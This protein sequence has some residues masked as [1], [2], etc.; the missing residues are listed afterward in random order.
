MRITKYWLILV[1]SFLSACGGDLTSPDFFP[2]LKGVVVDSATPT[3]FDQIGQTRQYKLLA[4]YSTPPGSNPEFTTKEVS[5][6]A[7]QSTNPT[8]ASV[9]ANGTVT[10]LRNGAASIRGSWGGFTS[11]PFS[12]S[13]AAPVLKSIS[14]DPASASVPLGLSQ[15]ITAIGSY[16]KTDGSTETHTVTELLS[17]LSSAPTVASVPEQGSTVTVSTLQQNATPVQIKASAV[18]ADGSVVERSAAIT[19]IAPELQQVVVLRSDNAA[20][21][22]YAVPRGASINLVAKGIYTDSSTPRDI[23][24]T[25]SWSSSDPAATVLALSNQPNGS[26]DVKGV[27]LGS[28]TVTVTTTKNDGVSTVSSVPANVTV[29]AAVLQSLDGARITPVPANVAI[30]ASLQLNVVGKYTDGTEAIVPASELNWTS[31]NTGI[32]TVSATGVALGKVQGSAVVTATLKTAPSSGAGS[33]ST[34]LTV[35]DAICTGPLL[36]TQG[37]TV[38][39]YTLPVLCL[40]CTVSDETSA[41]D[42]DLSTYAGLNVNLGLLGGYAELEVTSPMQVPITVEG[43]RAGFIISRP[44]GELLSL[45]LLGGVTMDTLD[46]SGNVLETAVTFDGLRLTL[47]GI[48]VIGQDAYVLSMPVTEPYNKLRLRMNAGLATVAQSLQINSSCAVAS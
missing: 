16:Q 39:S 2:Q 36:A 5:A 45:A 38:S 10:A 37:A 46:S 35:T 28:A 31:S 44:P 20:S 8:V 26:V 12:L 25:V 18:A 4:L 6:D 17:W 48:Y 32:A 19:V 7:W 43:Q 11:E 34:T 1:I 23:P 33:V 47:L 15:T 29:G 24:G 41:I 14:L 3:N 30:D 42:N 21:P 22:P 27:S 40:A 9:S 13:V